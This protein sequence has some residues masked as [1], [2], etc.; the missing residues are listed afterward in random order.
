MDGRVVV[1]GGGLGG[2]QYFTWFNTTAVAL[3]FSAKRHLIKVCGNKRGG[4]E[5]EELEWGLWIKEGI[6]GRRWYLNS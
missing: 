2:T 3:E 1:G 6:I 5:G 4:G